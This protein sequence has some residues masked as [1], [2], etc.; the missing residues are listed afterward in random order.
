MKNSVI[1]PV[2]NTEK[3]VEQCVSSVLQQPGSEEIEVIL[4]DD[5]ST[6][7]SGI[8]CDN[9][10]K[11][12]S[13][14]VVVHQENKG[15]A[16]ARNVG[17][18]LAR[19]EYIFFLDSD[20]FWTT[21]K[22]S[23]IVEQLNRTKPD[24]MLFSMMSFSEK[25]ESDVFFDCNMNINIDSSDTSQSILKKYLKRDYS[26]GWCPV[27]YAVRKK[28]LQEHNIEFPEGYLC[29]D[30]HF[31]FLLWKYAR[32]VDLSG[33][34]L[35]NYRR[36]NINSTTHRATFKFSDDLLKMIR[37]NLSIVHERSTDPELS[38]LIKLNFQTLVNVVLFWFT[39]YTKEEQRLLKHVIHEMNEIY[40][41]EPEAQV[42]MRNK[43]KV[44]D[45]LLKLVGVTGT[46]K[47]WGLKRKV[48][49]RVK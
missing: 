1:I 28:L 36:D 5:G 2:Y 6:D 9:L 19:G 39:S 35:Y 31:S 23:I 25:K 45:T 34:Y 26:F 21:N 18:S 49:S 14:V 17:L 8:I 20:D 27:W 24:L 44:V 42:Y 40:E 41:I 4:V 37:L 48:N 33:T 29:E 32:K 7:G 12:D 3:Y 15:Q 16:I 30:V 47:L 38:G 22:Y 13:R 10:A 11:K 43:E 46:A